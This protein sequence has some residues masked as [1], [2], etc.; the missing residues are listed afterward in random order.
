MRACEFK[1]TMQE[2]CLKSQELA[3]QIL[4]LKELYEE[5]YDNIRL[6]DNQDVP[7]RV[8]GLPEKIKDVLKETQDSN[9][10]VQ[11]NLGQ[12]PSFLGVIMGVHYRL[13]EKKVR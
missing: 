10:Q 2:A 13:N 5:L 4:R 7:E 1:D 11:I 3:E 6:P 9:F 12:I 8:K